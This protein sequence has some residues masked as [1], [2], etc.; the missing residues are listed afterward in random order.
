[1]KEEFPQFA[2]RL[3]NSRN[4]SNESLN[5]STPKQMDGVSGRIDSQNEGI[6]ESVTADL[7]ALDREGV[8]D[9]LDR[10]GVV[11]GNMSDMSALFGDLEDEFFGEYHEF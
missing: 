4:A 6:P 1:M 7:D 3:E 9:E 2:Q 5:T 8:V 10:E 11:P